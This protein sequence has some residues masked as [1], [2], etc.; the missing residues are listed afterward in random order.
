MPSRGG[1]SRRLRVLACLALLAM[2]V[3]IVA[4]A[5]HTAN[6]HHE[7]GHC[8]ICV[9]TVARAGGLLQT[10]TISVVAVA[11][12]VDTRSPEHVVRVRFE[13]QRIAAPRGPPARA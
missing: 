6:A 13:P 11:L 3:V 1:S 7:T 9:A 10:P 12:A 5:A 4:G 8:A 2:I